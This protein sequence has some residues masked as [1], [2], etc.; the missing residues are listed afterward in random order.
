[1]DNNKLQKTRSD[2]FF[3]LLNLSKYIAERPEKKNPRLSKDGRE[4]ELLQISPITSYWENGD[5]IHL[6]EA[7]FK[8]RV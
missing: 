6:C 1:M 3:F 5:A 7:R 8:E 4:V 2:S